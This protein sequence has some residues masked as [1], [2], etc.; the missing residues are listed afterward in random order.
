[1]TGI[2]IQGAANRPCWLV[3]AP[4]PCMQP[5]IWHPK[6][7]TIWEITYHQSMCLPA[8]IQRSAHSKTEC[9]SRV[10]SMCARQAVCTLQQ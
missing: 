10:L 8:A 2:T 7:E 1:M 4:S 5:L 6:I 3:R 9:V